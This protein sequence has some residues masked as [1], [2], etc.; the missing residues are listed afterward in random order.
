MFVTNV[1][2]SSRRVSQ[3]V[4]RRVG[5]VSFFLITTFS[6]YPVLKSRNF[7]QP[8]FHLKMNELM[9]DCWKKTTAQRLN[10]HQD[11]KILFLILHILSFFPF[12]V[13]ALLCYFELSIFQAWRG[14]RVN[15]HYHIDTCFFLFPFYCFFFQAWYLVA[16]FNGQ[17]CG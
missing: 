15:L 8:C 17:S 9:N 5:N 1:L 2:L 4:L 3:K 6:P 14:R 7:W 11:V 16:C 13:S 12:L 10:C